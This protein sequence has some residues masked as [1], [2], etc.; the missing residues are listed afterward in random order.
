[1][2]I[3]SKPLLSLVEIYG[4]LPQLLLFLPQEKSLALDVVDGI[5]VFSESLQLR[6]LPLSM[7]LKTLLEFADLPYLIVYCCKKLSDQY[8]VMM[9]R[10][11]CEKVNCVR[12]RR[13]RRL[14]Y[15]LDGVRFICS[16]VF[17]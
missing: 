15:F 13:S 2:F 9:L 6:L 16:Q 5:G 17:F 10:H 14:A 8:L 12:C 1:M 11:G 3:F 4:L 7:L